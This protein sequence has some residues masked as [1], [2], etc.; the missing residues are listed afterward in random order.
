MLEIHYMLIELM[1]NGMFGIINIYHG[2][3]VQFEFIRIVYK[4][5]LK[6]S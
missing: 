4:V 6:S 2:L 3:G 5:L 1:Y